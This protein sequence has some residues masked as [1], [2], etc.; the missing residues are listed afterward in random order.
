[1]VTGAA[2]LVVRLYE[3]KHD[4]S[5]HGRWLAATMDANGVPRSANGGSAGAAVNALMAQLAWNA[6]QGCKRHK[7]RRS[8]SCHECAMLQPEPHCGQCGTRMDDDF[9]KAIGCEGCDRVFCSVDCLIAHE[10][11]HP[12]EAEQQGHGR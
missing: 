3:P 1:M 2:G 6:G 4:P 8:G 11:A 5:G 9:G 10:L 7:A 12:E